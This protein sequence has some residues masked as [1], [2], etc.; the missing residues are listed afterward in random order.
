MLK[1][2]FGKTLS[3][4][5]ILS[6]SIS[7]I[8]LITLPAAKAA[9][10]ESAANSKTAEIEKD[11]NAKIP[12][13]ITERKVIKIFTARIILKNDLIFCKWFPII[14]KHFKL[15]MFNKITKSFL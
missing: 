1:S 12:A 13:T 7:K 2:P 8:S 9:D 11:S 6:I 10:S 14:N 3:G 5:L 4:L 15:R